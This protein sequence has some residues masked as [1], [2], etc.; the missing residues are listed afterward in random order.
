[1]ASSETGPERRGFIATLCMVDG[2][3]VSYGT[4]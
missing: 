2:L 3:L 1:M 4:V